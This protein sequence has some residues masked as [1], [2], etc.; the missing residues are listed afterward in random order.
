MGECVKNVV[1]GRCGYKFYIVYPARKWYKDQEVA[2][3]THTRA[4]VGKI[5]IKRNSKTY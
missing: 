2:C 5:I 4:N 1:V 3:G